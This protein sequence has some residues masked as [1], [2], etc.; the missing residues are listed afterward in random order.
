[1]LQD[2]TLPIDFGLGVDSKTDPKLVVIGKLL[3]LENG[4]FTTGK[5]V[6]KRNG[7]TAL[8]TT[9]M[10]GPTANLVSPKLVK[11]YN[12]ELVCQDSGAFYAYSPSLQAWVYK[13]PY[14]STEITE[15]FLYKEYSIS[16]HVDCAVLG[17]FALYV[18][19]NS[20]VPSK[21][22]TMA[23]VVDLS[24]GTTVLAATVLS[25]MTGYSGDVFT[26]APR[27]VVLGGASLAVTYIKADSSAVVMRIL[28]ITGLISPSISFGSES[29]I[30][31]MSLTFLP[32]VLPFDI[33]GTSTG[34]ILA[35]QYSN[36]VLVKSI[37]AS[38]SVVAT[39]T[40]T[41]TTSNTTL[42]VAIGY[43]SASGNAWVYWGDDIAG[44]TNTASV[45]YVIL[46]STLTIVL[47]ATTISALSGLS[48]VVQLSVLPV[49]STSQTLYCG[50]K[51]KDSGS[52]QTIDLTE[53]I[54]VPSNGASF[55][56][57]SAFANGVYPYSKPFT[58]LGKH[59]A[60]FIY[61]GPTSI[62][63]GSQNTQGTYFVLDLSS[64]SVVAR[65]AAGL[66]KSDNTVFP[67][68]SP[69]VAVLPSNRA[70]FPCG[71][72]FQYLATG[73]VTAG[74]V[75]AASVQVDFQS[76]R[77]YRAT[78]AAE[79]LAL[80]G[81]ILSMYDGQECV[82]LGFH[83]APEI[84][85]TSVS[86]VGG[87]IV[88]G[89]SGST[90][91]SFAYVAVFQWTDAQGNLHESAT[92]LPASV[93][94]SSGSTNSV[95]LTVSMAFLSQKKNINVAIYRTQANGNTYY[96]VTD[97]VNVRL[98]NAANSFLT[99]TDTLADNSITANQRVY[100]DGNVVTNSPPPP[101]MILEAHN[102][103]LWCVDS[104]NPNT[105]WYSKTYGPGTGLSLSEFLILEM[106]PKQG[107]IS[108]LSEMDDKMIVFKDRGL[109]YFAGDGANDT[110]T[111]STLTIPQILPSECGCNSL[112]SILLTPNGVFYKT[113]KGI[114][115]LDRALQNHYIGAEVEKY[116]AQS[117]T[118][119]TIVPD[120]NQIRFLT[121][122]GVTLVY[123]T[124]SA[125]W[126]WFT[127]HQ[128][129]AADSYQGVYV[130]ARTDGQIFQENSSSYLDG[131]TS[132]RLRAQL[133]WLALAGVQGF[134]RVR[135]VGLLG[136]FAG[137]SGHGVQISAAYDFSSTFQ[138]PVNYSFT[139]SSGP[140]QYRE[141]LPI[142]KC[143]AVTLLIEEVTTGASGESVDFT[144][145][146]LEA[147]VKRGLNKLSAANSVG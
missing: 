105:T 130:Y 61:R 110:G 28:N 140:F 144:N 50:V 65:F 72:L 127:N 10:G 42:P 38:G 75:G 89:I 124:Q 64:A 71:V 22:D 85:N 83:L 5:R 17:N 35:Y 141:R 14:T 27:A 125:Q 40:Q 81:G 41:Q 34:A 90:A 98:S 128:G 103:R 39:F 92:S 25:S 9:T 7:Y 82:E 44:G 26:S 79:I 78:T 12:G 13:G 100:T 129:Y 80:N 18:W 86:S 19:S 84:V 116:N 122:S 146:S 56:L 113:P 77:G 147:G 63:S 48:T 53:S 23:T 96:K 16:G 115:L 11:S 55:G 132:Y 6:T 54:S 1:M 137:A 107:N 30:G 104:E 69:N 99:F 108:G 62:F 114:Y 93:S 8:P 3:L 118:A 24:T 88:G 106:D 57:L 43:D 119:A 37:N 133:S 134:Q 67:C 4:V 33:V 60:V 68:Y 70:I 52:N 49:S 46:N 97:P 45:R 66:A 131:A 126:S 21:I 51:Y 139:G 111:G 73:E 32:S 142:Q 143:D 29:T 123:D 109:F 135:R 47:S 136:D 117:I 58:V 91:Y 121:D 20:R 74:L 15:T 87:H 2:Q 31:P 36:Q 101:S 95:T 102:N 59:Y 112:K 76:V 120:R 145:L 138:A 94:I